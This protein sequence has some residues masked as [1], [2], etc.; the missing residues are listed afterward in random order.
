MS[1]YRWDKPAEP[2]SLYPLVSHPDTVSVFRSLATYPGPTI[3]WLEMKLQSSRGRM[4]H[5]DPYNLESIGS[6]RSASGRRYFL[7]Y[8]LDQWSPFI[9]CLVLGPQDMTSKPSS[10]NMPK[11]QEL[12]LIDFTTAPQSYFPKDNTSADLTRSTLASLRAL[13]IRQAATSDPLGW[14]HLRSTWPLQTLR[15]LDCRLASIDILP[16][17]LESMKKVTEL[18]L[19]FPTRSPCKP[20]TLS[21]PN[22]TVK[23]IRLSFGWVPSNPVAIDISIESLEC[24]TITAGWIIRFDAAQS[25]RLRHVEAPS[26]QLEGLTNYPAL[27]PA[28]CT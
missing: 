13:T 2:S 1:N 7:S 10:L 22:P 8:A 26:C 6:A 12:V 16:K 28:P 24:F 15:Y 20:L 9:G 14:N 4:L 3:Q 27:D 18:R 21:L 19:E 23:A 17:L 5:L 25:G 11:L